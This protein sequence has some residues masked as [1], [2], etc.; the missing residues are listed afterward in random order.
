[1]K[2]CYLTYNRSTRHVGL[3]AQ[4]KTGT[5]CPMV[6]HMK[7]KILLVDDT[8]SNILVLNEILKD[9]GYEILSA[10][11]GDDALRIARSDIPDLILLDVV[12]SDQDGYEVC[13]QLKSDARTQLIPVIFITAYNDDDDEA[14]G[15]ELGAVDYITKPV[16]P[17]IVRARVRTHLQLKQQQ[18]VMA[19][20]SSTDFL[21][22]I[23][24]RRSFDE[25][26]TR[27]VHNNIC[28]SSP[29]TLIIC[30]IDYFKQY[31]DTYN[32]LAG[33]QC[34]KTIA[35][36]IEQI[37]NRERDLVARYGGEE[38]VIILPGTDVEKAT[39]LAKQLHEKVISLKILNKN[40]EIHEYLTVSMGI[41]TMMDKSDVATPDPLIEAA[42]QALYQAK[43]NGRNRIEISDFQR[44]H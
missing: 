32:H 22:G 41:A 43:K 17:A 44:I 6:K 21:T 40:S 24:N 36:T 39:E 27:E 15:F 33:D 14:Y 3:K 34:L 25:A 12:M 7:P 23:A 13:R 18:D 42:D 8:P 30:D 11:N 37:F 26:I 10:N 5:A 19:S 2:T 1:M 9:Q 38:F 29:L 20:I 35:K 16:K 28:P 4:P 31:N